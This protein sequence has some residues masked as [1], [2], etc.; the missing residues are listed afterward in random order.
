MRRGRA[1]FRRG[2]FG[3]AA[4]EFREAIGLNP[5]GVESHHD[6]GIALFQLGRFDSAL[7]SFQ[8]AIDLNDRMGQAWLN[9]GNALCACI[10]MQRRSVGIV[11][12]STWTPVSLDGH[13]NLANAFKSL[14]RL[15]KQSV[16]ISGRWR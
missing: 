5:N 11:G 13:Y 8:S 6:L 7:A 3:E 12:S 14:D 10:G 15:Q 4:F 9:G 2:D 16:T 1:A